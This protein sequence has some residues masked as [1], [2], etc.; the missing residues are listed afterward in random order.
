MDLRVDRRHTNTTDQQ[1]NKDSDVLSCN[2]LFARE[3]HFSISVSRCNAQHEGL[4]W[5]NREGDNK[6]M[7]D[8]ESID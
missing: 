6:K 3:V 1:V 4:L 5:E 7:M 2:F 8:A